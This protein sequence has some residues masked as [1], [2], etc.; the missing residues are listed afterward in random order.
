MHGAQGPGGPRWGLIPGRSRSRADGRGVYVR[1]RILAVLVVLLV[2]ALLIPRA[3]QA[4][5]ESDEA[6]GSREDRKTGA[7]ETATGD[8]AKN[9]DTEKAGT[10]DAPSNRGVPYIDKDDKGGAGSEDVSGTEGGDEAAPDLAA[11]IV[12][13][14]VIGG[15]EVSDVEVAAGGGSR[16]DETPQIPAG[17]SLVARLRASQ[18]SATEPQNVPQ[19]F[20]AP[21]GRPP[22]DNGSVPTKRRGA[23]RSGT[24]AP[25]ADLPRERV[26]G[27][28]DLV[29]T[30]PVAVR[31][32]FS[33]VRAWLPKRAAVR[34]VPTAPVVDV[35]V[36]PAPTAIPRDT[37]VAAG[38]ASVAGRLANNFGGTTVSGA[39][40]A[41]AALSRGPRLAATVPIRTPRSAIFWGRAPLR[42]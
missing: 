3:C 23:S 16:T 25:V 9:A 30:A 29:A 10:K 20:R 38:G 32:R 6:T 5:L 4:L 35:P 21:A 11:M 41:P 22:S 31:S 18:R 8:H 27:G 42:R 15:D 34:P 26:R 37:A 12:G 19:T 28:G 13:P 24:A 39:G 14:A 1:R 2:L 40:P 17:P 36:A 33:G 7:A